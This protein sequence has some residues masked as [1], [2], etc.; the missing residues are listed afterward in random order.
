[1]NDGTVDSNPDTVTIVVSSPLLPANQAPT[2]TSTPVTSASVG[3]PYSYDVDATDPDAGD[4]LTY[5]LTTAPAGMTIDSVTGLIDWTPVAPGIYPVIAEVRDS[6]N[7]S[8]TQSFDVVVSSSGP[9][10]QAPSLSVVP[11]FV[12]WQQL[13]PAGTPP[14]ARAYTGAMPYDAVNDRLILFGGN[15]T[16]YSLPEWHLLKL[17]SPKFQ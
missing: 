12:Q 15:D 14:T 11:N 7:L 1:M 2:I 8:A 17:F 4:V 5:T 3:Q 10:N 9:A 6:G 13:T 16:N